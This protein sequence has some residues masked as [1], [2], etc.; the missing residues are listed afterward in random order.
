LALI[1]GIDVSEQAN[2]DGV[3]GTAIGRTEPLRAGQRSEIIIDP[4]NGL[5]I[6]E[7]TFMT[8]AVFGFGANEVTGS[9]ALTYQVVDTA[10]K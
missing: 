9:T 4:T 1:P 10:P 8:Y 6:G 5:V 2:L 3:V 7:R